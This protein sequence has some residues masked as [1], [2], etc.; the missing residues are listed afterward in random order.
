MAS[1]LALQLDDQ[2]AARAQWKLPAARLHFGTCAGCGRIRDD[3]G[4]PLLVARQERCRHFL[5][6]PC[7]ARRS[8]R[9]RGR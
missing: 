2:A 4:R 3:D 6:F 1:Q 9:R 8:G 5:C 7:W